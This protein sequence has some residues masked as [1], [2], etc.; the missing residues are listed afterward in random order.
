[1]S[2]K[3]NLVV[4]N[5]CDIKGCKFQKSK[6]FPTMKMCTPCTLNTL[7]RFMI[8]SYPVP[9]TN[10]LIEKVLLAG[11][12]STA[13]SQQIQRHFAH[14]EFQQEKLISDENN[15]T[16]YAYKDYV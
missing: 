3:D 1:M 6:E 10:E 11:D 8:Y 15:K 9:I 16:E 7:R 2:E 5:K 13:L 12:V 4:L 14:L